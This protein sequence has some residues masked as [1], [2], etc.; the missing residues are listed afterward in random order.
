MWS[1]AEVA[2]DRLVEPLGLLERDDPVAAADER[3]AAEAALVDA[4]RAGTTRCARLAQAEV[5]RERCE[6]V[7][8]ELGRW[9]SLGNPTKNDPC[10]VVGGA[11]RAV[12]ACRLRAQ[13][14][15]PLVAP[16]PPV[17][18]REGHRPQGRRACFNAQAMA[19]PDLCSR[20]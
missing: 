14:P 19:A 20:C 7:G 4:T 10:G 6:E 8:V 11:V 13:A 18:G 1:Y 17:R 16:G 3:V 15:A 2:D 12:G 5:G 9:S